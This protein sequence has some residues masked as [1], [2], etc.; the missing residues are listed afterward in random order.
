[1]AAKRR[2]ERELAAARQELADAKRTIRVLLDR[3]AADADAI[4]WMDGVLDA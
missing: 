3:I 1:M 4:E 2:L